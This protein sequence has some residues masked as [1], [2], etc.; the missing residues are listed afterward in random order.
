M[1]LTSL[2]IRDLATIADVT[3][4]LGPGLNVLT[5]ET[6]AGKSMLVD[7][8]AL[9]LGDR[10]DRAAIRPGAARTVVEGVFEQ[11]PATA[12]ERVESLG[13][14]VEEP[15]VVRREVTAE[16]RSRAWINGSPATIGTL[17][18]L[19]E[20]LA[21]MHGQHQTVQLLDAAV[22]R[23]LLDAF[24]DA[25]V[26]LRTVRE[27]AAA[28]VALRDE[29]TALTARLDTAV[30]RADWLRHMVREIEA[31]RLRLGEDDALDQEALRLG[32]AS[33]LAEHA[34]RIADAIEGDEQGARAV[35]GRAERA[36][37]ALVRVD[38]S[39]SDWQELIDTAYTALDELARRARDY[40]STLSDDPARL[41]ELEGRRDLLHD[42]KRRHGPA[43]SDVLATLESGRG[44]LDVLDTADVDL[45]ALRG[46]IA[47]AEMELGARAAALTV[48]RQASGERI[49]REV[50]RWLPRLGLSGGEFAVRLTPLAQV[51]PSGAEA[52]VFE[53]RLNKGMTARALAESASGGELSRIMLA[54]KVALARHDAVPTLVFD[55]IDQGVG[56]E[57][58]GRIGDAL[59]NVAGRHQVLVITHLPQIAARAD[60]HLRVEKATRSGLATSDVAVLH[61]EDRV[62]ELA[63]MLGNPEDDAARRLA[64]SLLNR[65]SVKA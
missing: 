24:A 20:T 22:Q 5:G 59:A 34:E 54:L 58:G 12:R 28:V 62:I 38:A 21:D 15:F 26:A 41:A 61:G 39:T 60:H 29:E 17:A 49:A 37:S 52:I 30:R 6:G 33:T 11:L 13:L 2:R 47:A 50:N 9:L 42:L 10:A 64:L 57:V 25:S 45:R 23:E 8:L 4:E 16:G 44:E 65:T 40:T 51:G 43:L 48:L 35:L 63:R 19:G 31:A 3:L 14:D 27:A 36:L 53:V 1:T 18:S 56:G 46:R 55:E 32:Q 7:A